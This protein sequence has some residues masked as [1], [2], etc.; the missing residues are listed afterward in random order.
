MTEQ[1]HLIHE[2]KW[3]NQQLKKENTEL[4]ELRYL[5]QTEIV[6]QRRQI[7]FLMGALDEANRATNSRAG[8]ALVIS[9]GE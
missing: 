2:L 5:D 1:E 6:Y 7:D 9:Y 8:N 3:E 4:K